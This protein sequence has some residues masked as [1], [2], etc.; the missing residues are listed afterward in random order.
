MSEPSRKRR[1][2]SDEAEV[3]NRSQRS[4]ETKK[5]LQKK[6]CTYAQKVNRGVEEGQ[7]S[8]KDHCAHTTDPFLLKY[9]NREPF[10]VKAGFQIDI[11][12]LRFSINLR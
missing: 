3:E 10:T 9:K 4:K 11:V 2:L 8:D 5:E 7:F 6:Y 12:N 1:R